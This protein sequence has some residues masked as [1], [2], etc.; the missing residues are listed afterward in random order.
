MR[1]FVACDVLGSE[2]R[3]ANPADKR[4]ANKIMKNINKIILMSA[5]AFAMV[6]ASQA[7]AGETLLSPRAKGNQMH[8]VA[9][10]SNVSSVTQSQTAQNGALL[11]PRA[12]GNQIVK[13][14]GT[15]NDPDLVAGTPAQPISPRAKSQQPVQVYQIAPVK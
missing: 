12:Q 3:R 10:T 9:A 1:D 4:K 13:V 2:K 6:T 15:N 14:A 5:V 8:T 11:S 7:R